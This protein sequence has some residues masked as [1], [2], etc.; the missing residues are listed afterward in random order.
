MILDAIHKYAAPVPGGS[1]TPTIYH[2]LNTQDIASVTVYALKSGRVGP[3]REAVV[4]SWFPK[5]DTSVI[6][7]FASSIEDGQYHVVVAG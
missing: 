2:G 4:V 7:E 1:S 5:D 6:L 3:Y